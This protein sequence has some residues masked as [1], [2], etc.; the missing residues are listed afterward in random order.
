MKI[1]IYND[2]FNDIMNVCTPC[3]SHDDLRPGLQHIEIQCD[4]KGHGCATAVDGFVM[5]QHTFNCEG[6]ACKFLI[7]P[8]KTTKGE[9]EI[10]ISHEDGRTTIDYGDEII[11]R[12]VPETNSFIDHYKVGAEAQSHKKTASVAVNPNYLQKVLKSCKKGTF[13]LNL[14]IYGPGDPIVL[15]SQDM[16][17]CLLLP[18]R[19]H[20]KHKTPAFFGG[21]SHG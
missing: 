16:A 14:D 3:V 4:G 20:E 6:D 8:C 5:A 19:L 9:F 2:T 10:T 12:R 21:E 17:L 1:T 15:H 18:L 11:S 13:Y 7:W